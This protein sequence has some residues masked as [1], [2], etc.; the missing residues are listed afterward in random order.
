MHRITDAGG[1]V[2]PFMLSMTRRARVAGANE[3]TVTQDQTNPQP[4]KTY[5]TLKAPEKHINRA[6]TFDTIH[7]EAISFFAF[8]E[9]V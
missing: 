4:P 1:A 3:S 6:F 8:E 9:H 5:V 7:R 2:G